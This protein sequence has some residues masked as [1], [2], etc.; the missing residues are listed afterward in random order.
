MAGKRTR[1][2][3]GSG[4]CWANT[5]SQL[6]D[7]RSSTR[8]KPS[9][10]GS[11]RKAYAGGRS[12]EGIRRPESSRTPHPACTSHPA[13]RSERPPAH[14]FLRSD[15]K[16]LLQNGLYSPD[17]IRVFADAAIARERA[18]AEGIDDRLARPL[19]LVAKQCIHA[20]L[21]ERIR[22]VVSQHHEM[23]A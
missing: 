11:C 10:E 5:D 9:R 4:L 16:P 3:K 8:R 22:I 15:A 23:F 13:T 2:P 20:V 19:F 17:V 6:S 7:R 14:A 12:Q 18:H 21:G 1:G